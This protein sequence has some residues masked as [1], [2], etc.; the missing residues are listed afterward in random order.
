[1]TDG[2][3]MDMANLMA[4]RFGAFE[5]PVNPAELKVAHRALPVSYTH[6]TLPT[7]A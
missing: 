5:F 2:L 4:M 3:V 1:M 6:L 7:K